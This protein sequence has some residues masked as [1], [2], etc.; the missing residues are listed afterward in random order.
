[1][2]A[3]LVSHLKNVKSLTSYTNLFSRPW[4]VASIYHKD[5][6]HT[7]VT[8]NADAIQFKMP[9]LSPT[10]TEGTIVKW[11][12]A[13]GD[14]I[15]PGDVVFEIQTDKA[16]VSVD[17]DEEGVMAKILHNVD[18]KMVQVGELVGIMVLAGED[19]QNVSVPVSKS[20]SA[21]T[22]ASS[23]ETLAPSTIQENHNFVAPALLGPVA[24]T[25]INA[26]NIDP[27]QIKSS[28]PRG[29]ITKSDVKAYIQQNSLTPKDKLEP[30]ASSSTQEKT[31][32]AVKPNSD[33]EVHEVD[34][35]DIELSN[36]RKI[37]A[38][39]LILSKTTIP[40]AY[41][42]S[43]CNVDKIMT[44]RKAMIKKD[45]KASMNDFII[46]A[47]AL[48]LKMVPEMNANQNANGEEGFVNLPSTDISIAVATD[49]GL[50]TPIVRN[51]SD[52]SVLKIS[53]TV[54]ALADKARKGK[55]QP[56]E[57]QG[58]SFSISNLGM[59]GVKEFS[60]VINP[61]Q[62]G[63][64][65]VGKTEAKFNLESSVVNEIAFTLSYDA[66]CIDSVR[67]IKFMNNLKFFMENPEL[68]NEPTQTF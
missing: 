25:L 15:F 49:T 28:G 6:F 1:M 55:L 51:A 18:S 57:Y 52:L 56:N 37:I 9:A 26:Y 14:A 59:F 32:Q 23:V 50:I 47:L 38:K 64:L 65:A 53:E 66:R 20:A 68:L 46:K 27:S 11:H 21:S 13:E 62:V 3:R 39:R 22:K 44:L 43:Y 54:K 2:S 12:K 60:A 7:Q 33:L 41:I 48:A 67:A 24:R 5:A 58:G 42:N 19:W 29:L 16:V 40:H 30:E 8:L 61:P 34:F 4:S 31:H 45:Q 17:A 10:M 35:E 63:I 36:M